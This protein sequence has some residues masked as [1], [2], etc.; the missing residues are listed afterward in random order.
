MRPHLE[1]SR[2]NL[3]LSKK[4]EIVTVGVCQVCNGQ[5]K[6]V[7]RFRPGYL[8][9]IRAHDEATGVPFASIVLRNHVHIDLY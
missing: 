7:M 4:G 3:T 9:S 5:F 1:R 8:E 6:S 2:E